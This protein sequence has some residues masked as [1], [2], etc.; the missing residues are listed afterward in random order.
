MNFYRTSLKSLALALASACLLL[1]GCDTAPKATP[2][3]TQKAKETK[4]AAPAA[5]PP[6]NPA[7]TAASA[8]ASASASATVAKAAT[9]SDTQALKDGVALYNNGEYN[10]AISKLLGSPEITKSKSKAVKVEALKY[11]A[12]SYCV[13][14]RTQLCRQQFDRALKIDPR[15]DLTPAEIGHPIWGPVFSSA[16]KNQIKTK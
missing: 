16:K 5:T 1:S 6:E 4:A 15:F 7:T 13:T 2:K 10:A 12:F 14:S 11:A 3:P 8:S 9:A